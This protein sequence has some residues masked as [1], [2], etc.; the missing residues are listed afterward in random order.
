MKSPKGR[1]TVTP[2]QG[3]GFVEQVLRDALDLPAAQQ[4]VFRRKRL[5]R[6]ERSINRRCKDDCDRHARALAG[7]QRQ[8]TRRHGHAVVTRCVRSVPNVLSGHVAERKLVSRADSAELIPTAAL[9]CITGHPIEAAWPCGERSDRSAGR[10]LEQRL[11]EAGESLEAI[12]RAARES[13]GR[14]AEIVQ[15]MKDDGTLAQLEEPPEGS[16]AG[17]VASFRRWH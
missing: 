12:T 17:S 9:R 14:I 8:W 7:R 13:G 11:P 6:R 16:A 3:P 1:T 2:H 10:R 4:R 15:S 5:P